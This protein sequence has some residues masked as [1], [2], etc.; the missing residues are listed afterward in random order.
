VKPVKSSAARVCDSLEDL[1]LTPSTAPKMAL[2]SRVLMVPPTHFHIENAI[3]VHMLDASGRTH[4]LDKVLA[5]NQWANL[6][7]TYESLELEVLVADAA[8]GLPDMVFTANQ[9]LPFLDPEGKRSAIR[10]NMFDPTRRK[11]V[12]PYSAF[13]EKHGYETICL[14]G[15]PD[16]LFFEGMGDVLWVPGRQFLLAGYGHR[17]SRPA[18]D[19]IAK[20]TDTEIAAFELRSPEFYHL[21]TCLSILNEHTALATRKGFTEIGWKM[22]KALFPHLI[23]IP[24]HEAAPPYFAG[25]AHCPDGR[26]VL[27][28]RGSR[29]TVKALTNAGFTPI[30]VDTSEFIKS[31]GS[32]FCMKMMLF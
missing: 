29:Q 5:A 13:L 12:G 20:I 28:Q 25:N 11:E 21:D 32:V 15:N 17:T 16:T 26:H 4:T 6:R 18:L 3:N 10:S 19:Q 27:L 24:D 22:L 2:P 30:E 8:P 1:T 23:E 31:G 14:D 9:V 7:R